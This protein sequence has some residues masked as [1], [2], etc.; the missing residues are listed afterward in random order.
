MKEIYTLRMAR[1]LVKRGFNPISVKSS[2]K[3]NSR[4]IYLFEESDELN[5]AIQTYLMTDALTDDY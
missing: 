4:L 3:N 5:Q 2:T 1:W